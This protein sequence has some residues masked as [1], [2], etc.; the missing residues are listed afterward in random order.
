M[1]DGK[2]TRCFGRVL[3]GDP[4]LTVVLFAAAIGVILGSNFRILVL[5]PTILVVSGATFAAGFGSHVD[6]TTIAFVLLAVVITLQI[7][8]VVGGIAGV[9]LRMRSELPRGSIGP[10]RYY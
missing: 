1:G 5:V 3:G 6:F 7:C 2:A 10:S 4:L 9:Y 8:Y